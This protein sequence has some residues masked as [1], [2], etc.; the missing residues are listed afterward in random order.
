[1]S[2]TKNEPADANGWVT[3]ELISRTN[4]IDE[5]RIEYEKTGVREKLL[6]LPSVVSNK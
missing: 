5:I 2:T 1:M 6:L 3:Y 4:G